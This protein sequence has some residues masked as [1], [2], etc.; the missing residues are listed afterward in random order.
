M[1][2]KIDPNAAALTSIGIDVGKTS[3]RRFST[4]SALAPGDKIS[5]RLK[6]NRLALKEAF[7][8]PWCD[9]MECATAQV[10]WLAS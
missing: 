7:Q 1:K 4:L 2:P 6:I 10:Y 8:L 9:L 5:F 3:A